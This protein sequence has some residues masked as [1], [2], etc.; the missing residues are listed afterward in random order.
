MH[1]A[2]GATLNPLR[3]NESV[4]DTGDNPDTHAKGHKQSKAP[5]ITKAS[6]QIKF[7][8][9]VVGGCTS[10][11]VFAGDRRLAWLHNVFVHANFQLSERLCVDIC[12]VGIGVFFSSVMLLKNWKSIAEDYTKRA[13]TTKRKSKVEILGSNVCEN[14]H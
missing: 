10:P 13:E 3:E 7:C 6:V 11:F 4:T 2:A 14:L 12:C 1:A 8:S 9:H 5:Q